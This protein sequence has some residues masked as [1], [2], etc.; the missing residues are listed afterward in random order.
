MTEAVMVEA[1]ED[2]TILPEPETHAY[3]PDPLR[4]VLQDILENERLR[5]GL[6]D[7]ENLPHLPMQLIEK[8]ARVAARH[9]TWK[10]H[11]DGWVAT[12]L[13]FPG[14]W[15]KERTREQTLDVLREVIQ[16]WALL[17]IEQR[18][19]DLPVIED[20]NLNVL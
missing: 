16:D 18:D 9:A 12:V 7:I 5:A 15:A 14:V 19:R 8:Y 11:P 10:R 4:P 20:I 2:I 1:V 3:G 17:K 13:G 6:A